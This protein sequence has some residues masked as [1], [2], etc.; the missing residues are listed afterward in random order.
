MFL[1]LLKYDLKSIYKS[2]Y[3]SIIIID[4]VMILACGLTLMTLNSIK[5]N[6]I[7]VGIMGVTTSFII[8]GAIVVYFYTIFN[9]YTKSIY[10]SEGYLVN[11]LPVKPWEIVLS[12][13]TSS[14]IMG[15][16]TIIC[17]II[18]VCFFFISSGINFSDI[19]NLIKYYGSEKSLNIMLTLIIFG[20]VVVI[21]IIT[22]II[23]IY[24]II[25]ISNISK[26]ERY[27]IIFG[28]VIYFVISQ[29]ESIVVEFSFGKILEN[30]YS[31][32]SLV[33]ASSSLLSSF[34]SYNIYS[35]IYS[36]IMGIIWY[37]IAVT[38]INK[39]LYI[40]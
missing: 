10:G 6:N 3:K 23:K 32:N 40:K 7:L 18:C 11:T 19:L 1:K 24:S 8:I 34:N 30:A 38:V 17:G 9:R 4:I 14:V 39:K 35:L 28:V 16:F 26:F 33:E 37:V 13:I 15:I 27:K 2:I 12:K 22:E 36:I 21:S 5:P 29:I 25:S 31:V 20:I